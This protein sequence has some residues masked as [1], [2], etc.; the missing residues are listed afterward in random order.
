M[1]NEAVGVDGSSKAAEG[2]E[3]NNEGFFLLVQSESG[4]TIL[5]VFDEVGIPILG[6]HRA[7]G[8]GGGEVGVEGVDCEVRVVGSV[9]GMS[10]DAYD[11]AVVG[12]VI[13]GHESDD[14]AEGI[15]IMGGT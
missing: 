5:E 8:N 9:A 14:G 10:C 2:V 6:H 3:I 12:G 15:L 7:R 13:H 1:E 4:R 11:G